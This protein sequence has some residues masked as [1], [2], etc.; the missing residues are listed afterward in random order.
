VITDAKSSVNSGNVV[1]PPKK[2]GSKTPTATT[3]T[4]SQTKE[5]PSKLIQGSH[6]KALPNQPASLSKQTSAPGPKSQATPSKSSAASDS[7]T[8][9]CDY[10][11]RC[12]ALEKRLE[13]SEQLTNKLLNEGQL[14]RYRANRN[15]A[16]YIQILKAL[17]EEGI[18]VKVEGDKADFSDEET[19]ADSPKET[20][21]EKRLNKAQSGS[22]EDQPFLKGESKEA[23]DRWING[24]GGKVDSV[25]KVDRSR[26]NSRAHQASTVGRSHGKPAEFDALAAGGVYGTV[27]GT[28]KK[29]NTGVEKTVTQEVE[30]SVSAVP[31]SP[32]SVQDDELPEGQQAEDDLALAV[33][34][35]NLK[36]TK[37]SLPDVKGYLQKKSPT[38][39]RGWQKRYFWV[40]DF[41][42]F[43]APTEV[44]MNTVDEEKMSEKLGWN[45]ISLVTVHSISAKPDSTDGEFIIRA[46]DPR[47]GQMRNYVMKADSNGDRDKWVRDLN[48]HRDHLLS[49]LRWA[50]AG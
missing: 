30:N 50:G 39:L 31:L 13:E 38:M 16:L 10:R 24:G 46:R 8:H 22:L 4:T 28:V 35:E 44:D 41:K 5:P 45:S 29:S 2:F 11:T 27:R 32:S 26:G 34:A 7:S 9:V 33:I 1:L 42:L 23:I 49:T 6:T 14:W 43:Y 25:G 18:N 37:D 3:T 17:A 19:G 47:T 20:H 40:K 36:Q 48:T 21:E 15:K 12:E